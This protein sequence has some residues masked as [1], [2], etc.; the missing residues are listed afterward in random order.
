VVR[1]PVRDRVDAHSVQRVWLSDYVV[2]VHLHSTLGVMLRSTEASVQG[3]RLL[4]P[5]TIRAVDQGEK[6]LVD[7]AD[8]Q[9]S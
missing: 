1:H 6:S 4:G 8:G 2:C 7:D 9:V 5:S 3:H